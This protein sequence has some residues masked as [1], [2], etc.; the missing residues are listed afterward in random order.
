MYHINTI[1][2]Y[3]MQIW[4]SGIAFCFLVV[5]T[6]RI[7]CLG[8]IQNVWKIRLCVD[9]CIGNRIVFYVDFKHSQLCIIHIA[10]LGL[11]SELHK[12]IY[13]YHVQH[14]RIKN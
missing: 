12:S 7:I 10:A 5:C 4:H 2:P 14:K 3:N 13:I 9:R 11:G 8:N 6:L 1:I